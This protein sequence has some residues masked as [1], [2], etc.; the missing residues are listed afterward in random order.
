MRYRQWKK[1][2]K[3]LR[4]HNPSVIVDGRKRRKAVRRFAKT[5][6]YVNDQTVS[7]ISKAARTAGKFR[8]AVIKLRKEEKE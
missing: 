5:Y 7:C 1:N 2:Y 4:G 6:K 3:N 8:N